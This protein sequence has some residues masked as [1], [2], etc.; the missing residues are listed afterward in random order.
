MGDWIASSKTD[1]PLTSSPT[2]ETKALSNQLFNSA[3]NAASSP[4]LT[5]SHSVATTNAPP[6]FAIARVFSFPTSCTHIVANARGENEE[7]EGTT[8][9]ACL[10]KC[11]PWR[12]VLIARPAWGTSMTCG[13]ESS[14]V[15]RECQGMSSCRFVGVD[16]HDCCRTHDTFGA[17]LTPTSFRTQLSYCRPRS[18]VWRRRR[19]LCLSALE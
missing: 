12:M 5:L 19:M 8:A 18:A 9:P 11:P 1:F 14:I 2:S 3:F 7:G 10:E 15:G 4:S 16:A 13:F 6:A 17:P